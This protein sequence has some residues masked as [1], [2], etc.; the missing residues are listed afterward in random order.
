MIV[1]KYRAK[2]ELNCWAIRPEIEP[3]LCRSDLPPLQSLCLQSFGGHSQLVPAAREAAT[4]AFKHT[5]LWKLPCA[6]IVSVPSYPTLLIKQPFPQPALLLSVG[7]GPLSDQSFG[8]RQRI[9]HQ[10]TSTPTQQP[11]SAST[12]DPF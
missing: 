2:E 8:K 1:N 12:E 7:E 10:E 4:A 11:L 3:Q 6:T 9:S 5:V